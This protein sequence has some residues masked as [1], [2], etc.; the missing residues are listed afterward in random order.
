MFRSIIITLSAIVVFVFMANIVLNAQTTEGENFIFTYNG[1][2]TIFVDETCTAPLS[3]GA[4]QNPVITPIL[5]GNAILSSNIF[6]S[7]GYQQ[8]SLVPAGVEV[9]V[10][11][12]VQDILNAQIDT[13][14]FTIQFVDQTPPIFDAA[15][16][17]ADITIS[18]GEIP[19]LTLGAVEDNCTNSEEIEIAISDSEEIDFCVNQQIVRTYTAT[20]EYGNSSVFV[21]N[22]M[23]IADE[24]VPVLVNVA[25]DLTVDCNN[26]DVLSAFQNWLDTRGGAIITDNCPN[27]LWTTLPENPDLLNSCNEAI[28]VTF[29]ATD[30]CGN[31]ASTTAEFLYTD[32]EPPVLVD[33]PDDFV[34]ICDGSSIVD[35]LSDWIM[36][37]GSIDVVDDCVN[38]DD[39]LVNVQYE[40]EEVSAGLIESLVSDQVA[41]GCMDNI[42]LNGSSVDGVLVLLTFEFIFTD[43]CGN[44]LSVEATFAAVDD[45][46]P[47]L[48]DPAQDLTINCGTQDELEQSLIAWLQDAG[49]ASGDDGCGFVQFN[50]LRNTAAILNDFRD[51]QSVSCG[52][53]GSIEVDFYLSDFCGNELPTPTR[54]TFTVIDTLAPVVDVNPIDVTIECSPNIEQQIA[55]NIEGY[56]E[57]VALDECGDVFWTTFEWSAS[58]GDEGSGIFGESDTYPFPNAEDCNWTVTF[59]MTVIDACGN[60]TS[61]QASLTVE[62]SSEPEFINVIEIQTVTC[63]NIPE[64][65]APEVSDN[66][67]FNLSVDLNETSDKGMDS[68]QCDFYSY[69]LTREWVAMDACGNSSTAIQTIHVI[70]TL[71]PVFSLPAMNNVACDTDITPDTLMVLGLIDDNC[72]FVEDF[73][74]TEVEITGS[75]AGEFRIERRYTATDVCGNSSTFV[76]QFFFTDT[77]GPSF[78]VEPEDLVLNCSDLHGIDTALAD[79]LQN[80]GGAS[81][82]DNCSE[83]DFFAAIPGSY[84]ANDPNSFP[85]TFPSMVEEGACGGEFFIAQIIDLVFFDECGNATVSQRRLIVIDDQAPEVLICQSEQVLPNDPGLCEASLVIQA[86]AIKDACFGNTELFTDEH[87][88]PISSVEPGNPDITV[89]SLAFEISIPFMPERAM[90]APAT[91]YIDLTAVDAATDTKFFNVFDEDGVRLGETQPVDAPCGNGTTSFQINDEV[92]LNRWVQ[93]GLITINLIPNNPAG[94]PG[95]NT[96]TDICMDATATVRIDYLRYADSNIT[97]EYAINDGSRIL[98]DPMI[99]IDTALVV[100]NHEL[101]Y[102]ITDCFGNEAICAQSIE[103]EDLESPVI[104]CAEDLIY[105]LGDDECTW[106]VEMDLPLTFEDNCGFPEILISANE[107]NTQLLTFSFDSG[108]D[109]FLVNDVFFEIVDFNNFIKQ[110]PVQLVFTLQG[111]IEAEESFFSIFDENDVLLGTTTSGQSNVQDGNCSEVSVIVFEV[112]GGQ[113]D[114]WAEDGSI[115]FSAISNRIFT[116]NNTGINPCDPEA[117]ETD[118]D[119]DGSSFI[120]LEIQSVG[121]RPS[122]FVTGK[123]EIPLSE[124]DAGLNKPEITYEI[125]TSVFHYLVR[126]AAG[127]EDTCQI[128]IEVRDTIAPVAEC[129]NTIIN[130]NPSGILDY[131][132]MPDEVDDGSFDNCDIVERLVAPDVFD[133]SQIGEEISVTL[134][135]VDAFG[136]ES[137]CQSI[138]RIERVILEP[139]FVLD[140]CNP[141]TLRL[142][143]NLPDGPGASN[144]T[145]SWIGPNG[146]SSNIQNPIITNVNT[147][148]SG[149]YRLMVQGFG[150]C[151]AEGTVTVVVPEVLGTP[152]L[153][154]DSNPVCEGSPIQLETQAFSGNVQYKWFMG[155]FPNGTE[156]ASTPSPGYSLILESGTYDFYV[157]IESPS[158]TSAPSVVRQ[159]TVLEGIEAMVDDEYIEICT[160][161]SLQLG[162]PITGPNIQYEWIGPGGFESDSR[163]PIVNADAVPVNSGIYTLQIFQAGCPSTIASVEV[164]VKPRPQTPQMITNAAACPGQQLI[165]TVNNVNNADQYLWQHPDGSIINTNINSLSIPSASESLNG[166][167]T[168]IIQI[169]ECNSFVSNE[170]T[171]DIEPLYDFTVSN[172]GPICMGDSIRLNALDLPDGTYVWSGP[173]QNIDSVRNPAFIPIPGIY[174]VMAMT[175]RG[176]AYESTTAVVVNERPTVTALS[177]TAEECVSGID[178]S[179]FQATVFPADPGNYMFEWTG[180]GFNSSDP[181]ACIQNTSSANNGVYTLSVTNQFGCVSEEQTIVLEVKDIPAKPGITTQP[182]YC[183]GESIVLNTNELS[184][185]AIYTWVT[186]TG[187]VTTMV[188]ELNIP[189]SSD[190]HIGQYSLSVQIDGCDSETSEPVNITLRPKPSR[191]IAMGDAIVCEGDSILLRTNFTPGASFDWRGPDNFSS[192][193][194]NPFVFPAVLASEGNYTL[195]VNVQGC[196]SASSIPFFVK[197]NQRPQAPRLETALDIVCARA[198]DF[199]LDLCVRMEDVRDGVRYTWYNAFTDEVLAGPF[200][201]RCFNITDLDRLEDGSNEFYV[202]ASSGGCM[203]ENSVTLEVRID[204]LPTANADAGTDLIACNQD[205]IM[206]QA[207]PPLQGTGQWILLDNFLGVEMDTEAAT[208]IF[209]LRP[210]ENFAVWSL[211]YRSCLDYSRDTLTITYQEAPFAED[212]NA[213]VP[214]A[215]SR[216]INILQN[217]QL[218]FAFSIDI[219]NQPLQGNLVA[220]GDNT[221][222]F[223]AQPNYVGEDQF[224][225]RICATGCPGLCSDA[226][227]FLEIGDESI[228]DVPNIITPNNDGINDI[229]FIPCLSSNLFPNNKVAI[230]NEWGATIFEESPYSNSWDGTFNGQPIPIGTYFYVVEFGNGRNPEKGFL[231]IKR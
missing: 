214:F 36:A 230:F 95:N 134:T 183:E 169:N 28:E 100:G 168:V 220:Q 164:F 94:L 218:P 205:E 14:Q 79:W 87:T 21:Q 37:N 81:A 47:V 206:V 199:E 29:I 66:C 58:N 20:D 2:D 23:V 118:G 122:Y 179:C 194:Q 113:L 35:E 185:G 157:I 64:A 55:D 174:T 212:D 40:G 151:S 103:I 91:I 192:T 195:T 70:D 226:I 182:F 197:V 106:T 43:F 68:T 116:G 42:M 6:I 207:A 189:V 213:Q 115:T 159:V 138:V 82:I 163:N 13:F 26:E 121:Y 54:A 120:S 154:F 67:R 166:V 196:T 142:V 112:S 145:F 24:Q 129:R 131:Q 15:M 111:D 101:T 175:G 178:E 186:P 140:V 51:S 52:R 71:G 3:W 10:E 4:P 46:L 228:C 84:D 144:Y 65:V 209:G 75:C 32:S 5:N 38:V 141:D 180:P 152:D 190:I 34:F 161:E 128:A 143:A 139:Q 155:Q 146:F 105:T 208:N 136:L 16:I 109:D 62:D 45:S 110:G 8:G 96:I 9:V 202:I 165:L 171:V 80:Q 187:T 76:Q 49:G 149:T 173:T 77:L 167:W 86:P 48:V 148:F 210:G 156:L 30:P 124:L 72:S 191:P 22:I 160:G 90:A 133:C 69:T 224:T 219:I 127:N 221:Y 56:F 18:C 92:R 135:V 217:D 31:S 172:N 83:V 227:V 184:T 93:D 204:K 99:P 188:P 63:D 11:Y 215:G 108:V 98:L 25:S 150:G 44:S 85:G 170:I 17:E 211:N 176:C 193:E 181:V 89:N 137:S 119:T 114:A 201:A 125:G 88:M 53:T 177:S 39:L 229:F 7:G 104:S 216:S 1:P 107:N 57:A 153:T 132:L 198:D 225:Y 147:S 203:S 41:S 117:V 158:C 97:F 222:E 162:T 102:F 27:L 123:T 59:D 78:E 19:T 50:T 61:A 223:I 231:T 74:Y 60:S 73:S 12:R 130:I 200:A 33:T 126:D